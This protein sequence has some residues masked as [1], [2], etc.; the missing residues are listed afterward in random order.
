M[1]GLRCVGGLVEFHNIDFP[2]RYLQKVQTALEESDFAPELIIYNAGTDIL[3][4]DRL[5]C[6]SVSPDGVLR[7]DELVQSP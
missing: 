3:S 4:G 7:R 6:L 2:H 5:G 1:Y